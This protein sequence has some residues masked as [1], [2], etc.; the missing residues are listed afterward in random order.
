MEQSVNITASIDIPILVA[1]LFNHEFN[2]LNNIVESITEAHYRI[3]GK[4]S[5]YF[6]GVRYF[7]IKNKSKNSMGV[8]SLAMDLHHKMYAYIQDKKSILLDSRIIEQ[9]LFTLIPKHEI[10]PNEFINR[11]PDV[12][13]HLTDVPNKVRTAPIEQFYSVDD[14]NKLSA[15]T[16]RLYIYASSHLFY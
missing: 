9:T 8:C 5:F 13:H 1:K 10:S 11:L 15:I 3:T 14:L 2:R 7:Y 6:K 4:D 12:L 16:P